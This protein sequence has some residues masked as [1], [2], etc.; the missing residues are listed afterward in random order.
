LLQIARHIAA[1]QGQCLLKA[2]PMLVAILTHTAATICCPTLAGELYVMVY[3]R[4]CLLKDGRHRTRP[5]LTT[6]QQAQLCS[7]L[8]ALSLER[9]LLRYGSDVKRLSSTLAQNSNN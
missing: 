3:K 7:R 6:V 8:S 4:E 9:R 1:E 2:L 5:D